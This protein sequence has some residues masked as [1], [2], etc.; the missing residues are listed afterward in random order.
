MVRFFNKEPGVNSIF[1]PNNTSL[2]ALCNGPRSEFLYCLVL[3]K[4]EE[5]ITVLI[6]K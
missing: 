3:V 2:M 4:S 1:S 6:S 5:Q